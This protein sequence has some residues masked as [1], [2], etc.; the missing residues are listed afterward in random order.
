MFFI[1]MMS[2]II[3]KYQLPVL[4][5]FTT[6]LL[7]CGSSGLKSM[8][9]KTSKGLPDQSEPAA[10]SEDVGEKT[11]KL[12]MT[13]GGSSEKSEGSD[14]KNSGSKKKSKTE[15]LAEGE[16]SSSKNNTAEMQDEDLQELLK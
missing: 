3:K 15:N 4:C 6:M 9:M 12:T 16:G 14:S 11:E 1:K 8:S 2:F 10:L 13:E 7:G 5:L